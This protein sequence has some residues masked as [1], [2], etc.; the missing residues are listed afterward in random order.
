MLIYISL[1][2]LFLHP[3]YVSCTNLHSCNL[4]NLKQPLCFLHFKFLKHIYIFA[5][6]TLKYFYLLIYVSVEIYISI[7]FT[8]SHILNYVCLTLE[9]SFWQTSSKIDKEARESTI[10][11]KYLFVDHPLAKGEICLPPST[12]AGKVTRGGP[13]G[14]H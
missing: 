6:S 7:A 3:F 12:L 4:L 8:F 5:Q 14:D 13:L 2:I 11:N 9:I 1:H 10:T